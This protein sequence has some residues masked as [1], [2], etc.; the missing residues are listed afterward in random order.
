MD[1][2]KF[3]KYIGE[4]LM[5]ARL[6]KRMTQATITKLISYDLMTKEKKAKGISYQAY[7]H[8][9]NGERS[10]P[11]NIF[12]YAC[13]ALDLNPNKVFKNAN[14]KFMKVAENDLQR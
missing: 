9:E 5:E 10:M 2:T 7:A 6:S 13:N 3:D 4:Q 11:S 8:Y 14:E 12:I 1:Y